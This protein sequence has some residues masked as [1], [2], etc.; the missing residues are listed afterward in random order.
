MEIIVVA[1]VPAK[2]RGM[3][4]YSSLKGSTGSAPDVFAVRSSHQ[5]L[6]RLSRLADHTEQLEFGF[7]GILS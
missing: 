4:N 5:R 2:R 7:H 6:R 1:L 3:S